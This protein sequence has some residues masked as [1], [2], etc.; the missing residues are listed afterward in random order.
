MR[1]LPTHPHWATCLPAS[2][3]I[4][5][6]CTLP[7]FAAEVVPISTTDWLPALRGGSFEWYLQ[8]ADALVQEMHARCAQ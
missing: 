2:S 1:L 4:I 3:H 7:S 6:T 5:L 8:R